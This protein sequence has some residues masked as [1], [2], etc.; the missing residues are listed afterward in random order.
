MKLITVSKVGS[1]PNNNRYEKT[2]NKNN[3]SSRFD[4]SPIESFSN[5]NNYERQILPNVYYVNNGNRFPLS[6]SIKKLSDPIYHENYLSYLNNQRLKE[7]HK[8]LKKN[9]LNIEDS[10]FNNNHSLEKHKNKNHYPERFKNNKKEFDAL[11]FLRCENFKSNELPD[12]FNRINDN[13]NSSLQ[14]IMKKII[15]KKS[16][17]KKIIMKKSMTEKLI[18][19][20]IIMKKSI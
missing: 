13:S 6:I 19:K 3:I 2:R 11:N 18:M 7:N 17:M 14:K 5:S 10:Y 16:I 8:I 1:I 15:M 12:L 20:K 4:I 9:L